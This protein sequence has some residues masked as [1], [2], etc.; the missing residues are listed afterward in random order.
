MD[1]ATTKVLI[2]F[3]E[4]LLE[5]VEDYRHENRISSRHQAILDLIEKGLGQE[6]TK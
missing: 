3:P 4:K 5:K 2:R 6:A 1:A